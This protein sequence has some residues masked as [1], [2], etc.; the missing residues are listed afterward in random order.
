MAFEYA[1]LKILQ[2]LQAAKRPMSLGE[3]RDELARHGFRFE[4]TQLETGLARLRDQGLVEALVLAGGGG[5][6]MAS[7]AI[8]A[9]GERKVRGIVRL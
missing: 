9:A 8:T 6:S 1:W 7:V 3:V 5:E 4:G 2:T